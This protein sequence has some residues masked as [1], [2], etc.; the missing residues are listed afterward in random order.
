MGDYCDETRGVKNNRGLASWDGDAA[1]DFT[2]H[3]MDLTPL[4]YALKHD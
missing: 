4:S 2:Y 3:Y 1:Y